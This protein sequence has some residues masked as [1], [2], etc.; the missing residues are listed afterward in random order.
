MIRFLL[1]DVLLM[2][3]VKIIQGLILFLQFFIA[4]EVFGQPAN[5][6]FENPFNNPRTLIF[7][8]NG[9]Y[10]Q[11]KNEKIFYYNSFT[12][13]NTEFIINYDSVIK[14]CY[15]KIFRNNFDSAWKMRNDLGEKIENETNVFN[16]IPQ[17]NS[18]CFFCRI[19]TI[20]IDTFYEKKLRN[21]PI[22]YI[23]KTDKQFKI[24]EIFCSPV[25]YIK[26]L[27]CINGV[28]NGEIYFENDSTVM[29]PLYHPN[30]MMTRA[31]PGGN[32]KY[33]EK[34]DL[35]LGLFYLKNGKITLIRLEGIKSLYNIS[36]ELN[37]FKSVENI[38]GGSARHF[39]YHSKIPIVYDINR[40]QNINLFDKDIDSA[41]LMKNINNEAYE[42]KRCIVIDTMLYI[43]YTDNGSSFIMYY[44]LA[45]GTNQKIALEVPKN[46]K[47]LG[48]INNNYTYALVSPS[49]IKIRSIK[50]S[51]R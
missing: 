38:S 35:S 9:N 21:I 41:G 7:N 49:D 40:N 45:S 34:L 28:P 27:Y 8:D 10:V 50:I 23:I 47:P 44:S 32:T 1:S 29:M 2:K 37:Q 16:F 14:S 3:S 31:T 42:I 11:T 43:F 33:N 39:A 25:R 36:S 51:E 6:T 48:L 17:K 22:I 46:H 5:Q 18:N 4:I 15:K 24:K 13:L 12:K 19:Y 26:D 30:I 20:D